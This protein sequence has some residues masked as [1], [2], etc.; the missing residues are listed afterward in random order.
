MG[1]LAS[2]ASLSFLPPKTLHFPSFLKETFC[3]YKL[4]MTILFFQYLKNAVPFRTPWFDEKL[5]RSNWH[6]LTHCFF[7]DIF[8]LFFFSLSSFVFRSLIIIYLITDFFQLLFGIPLASEAKHLCFSPNLGSL[9]PSLLDIFFFRSYLSLFWNSNETNISSSV[10]VTQV[11]ETATLFSLLIRL[12]QLNRSVLKFPDSILCHLRFTTEPIHWVFTCYCIF[13]FYNFHLIH[14][15]T[16][17]FFAAIFYFFICFNSW[18]LVEAFSW[19]LPQNPHQVMPAPDH[20][21]VDCLFSVI[22]WF[23][24]FL[25]YEWSFIVPWIFLTLCYVS[26]YLTNLHCWAGNPSVKV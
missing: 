12:G 6:F 23:F 4:L 13:H 1:R 2:K 5:C 3:R 21:S 19:Q 8:E 20:L 25:E 16:F 7:L 22:V 11:P 10:I 14:S 18:L 15:Y 24:C 17:Y 26:L 9:C